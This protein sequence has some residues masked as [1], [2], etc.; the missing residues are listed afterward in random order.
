MAKNF[1]FD[2][3]ATD[4]GNIQ[5]TPGEKDKS[6]TI[7]V[8]SWNINGSSAA[9]MAEAR[10]S[11]LKSVIGDVDPDV[12][13]LQETIKSIDSFFKDTGIPEKDYNYEKAEDERE[14]RVI[15]K[16]NAFEKVDPSPVHLDT[17]LKK[18]PEE[19]TKVLRE[20]IVPER[21]TIK[22]RICVV[23]LR[24]IS[25]KREIIFV[26]F[27]N[28]RHN[29][30]N[31]ATK[32]CEIIASLHESNECYVIAGVDFNCD[33]FEHKLV[34]VPPYTTTLRREDKVKVDYYILSNSTK[35]WE[36]KAI[37]LAPFHKKLQSEEF[38]MDLLNKA[39]DHDP[40]QLS[41]SEVKR[42]EE[43]KVKEEEEE[44]KKNVPEH[45]VNVCKDS[46]I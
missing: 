36:V 10:K 37:D 41:L 20:G 2:Q 3:L 45:F 34:Q 14:T 7:K 16:N 19:E 11:I 8:L 39:I 18:V 25:T 15:Y 29:G 31:I 4:F 42:E 27:H 1:E 21:R 5:L 28:I 9:G 44:G 30:E 43:G 17:V 35:T 26:S 13:L 22:N 32:V 46:I 24:H 6:S 23:H 12:M 40:L 38:Q 33:I